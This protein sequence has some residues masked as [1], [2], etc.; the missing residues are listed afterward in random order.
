LPESAEILT[1]A[2][3][4]VSPDEHKFDVDLIRTL[5]HGRGN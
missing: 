5:I 1:Y 4:S 2:L 3:L